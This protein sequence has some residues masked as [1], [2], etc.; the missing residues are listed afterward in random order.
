MNVCFWKIQKRFF[1]SVLVA[2]YMMSTTIIAW[3]NI[4]TIVSCYTSLLFGPSAPVLEYAAVIKILYRRG[5]ANESLL[6]LS[7]Y[8][9]LYP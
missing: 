1:M 5:G 2:S 6:I 3:S 9:C 8:C 4:L 7:A